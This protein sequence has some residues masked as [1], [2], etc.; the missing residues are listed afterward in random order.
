MAKWL[1]SIFRYT[2]IGLA[3]L[4]LSY[5]LLP[6]IGLLLGL[7]DI[8]SVN[9][10]TVFESTRIRYLLF[11]SL[12]IAVSVGLLSSTLGFV[13]ASIL[14]RMSHL[15]RNIVAGTLLLLYLLSP[16]LLAQSF[17][18]LLGEK[19][20]I[21]QA[22][23]SG[24]LFS[25][26]TVSG[27]IAIAT[28][29]LTPL[30]LIIHLSANTLPFGYHDELKALNVSWLKWI[31]Y[32]AFP[33]YGTAFLLSFGLCSLV[34]F[35]NYDLASMLRVNVFPIDVMAAFGS[36]YDYK[37]ALELIIFP[38]VMS[39]VLL[40]LLGWCAS[41]H[42]W[43]AT[44]R[45]NR[46]NAQVQTGFT[47]VQGLVLIGV[48]IGYAIFLSS[49]WNTIGNY[50]VFETEIAKFQSEW[51]NTI[52]YGMFGTIIVLFVSFLMSMLGRLSSDRTSR[53]IASFTVLIWLFP[54]VLLGMG[55]ISV[56]NL[57]LLEMGRRWGIEMY[58]IGI[59]SASTIVP[60]LVVVM[61]LR[62]RRSNNEALKGVCGSIWTRILLF[63]NSQRG[64]IGI[65][66]FIG[67]ATIVREVPAGLLNMPPDGSTLALSIETLLHFEQPARVASICLA[68]FLTIFI[69]CVFFCFLGYVFDQFNKALLQRHLKV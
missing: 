9:L 62:W 66:L 44:V 25:I 30:A 38:G 37:M 29:W 45:D 19:G 14:K 64:L 40:G 46:A 11:D 3:A 23:D 55:W 61:S 26:Y 67:F 21:W 12:R 18:A 42:L 27:V 20:I 6:I 1:L 33:A 57:P 39:L 24:A 17:I 22:F 52:K 8:G 69:C 34:A 56:W 54:P 35:W 59:H 4:L 48:L 43:G 16:Y 10:L 68:Y 41:K 15:L 49:L 36:F 53:W 51:S 28:I 65:L 5:T 63:F 32:Y 31:R 47:P 2:A 7:R 60:I 58:L 50:D 13:L